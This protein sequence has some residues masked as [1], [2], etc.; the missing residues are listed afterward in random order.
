MKRFHGHI[1]PTQT[2]LQERPEILHAVCVYATIHV[3][4]RMVNDPMNVFL[5]Q[6]LIA[7]HLV[8]DER[9]PRFDVLANDGVQR[10]LRPIR[11]DLSPDRSATLQ[12]SHDDCLIAKTL[13]YTSDSALINAFVHVAR[14]AADKSFVRFYFAIEFAAMFILHCQTDAMQHEPC[15]FLSDLDVS[16]DF[17]ATD[18]V[19]AVSDHP[20]NREPLIETNRRIFKDGPDLDRELTARVMASA[21]PCA[22]VCVVAD[23]SGTATWADDAIRPTAGNKV[24]NAIIG[25]REVDDRFLKA[26][27]FL[28]HNLLPLR[29]SYLNLVGESSK[30]SPSSVNKPSK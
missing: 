29:T 24:L 15:R 26:L 12:H 16:R 30:L 28:A 3:S 7:T 17:I 5:A 27:R 22:A 19:L 13:T 8:R 9:R 25:I 10:G 11:D 4:D 21:L 6:S 18:A 2:A 14:F 1:R 20:S 23:L